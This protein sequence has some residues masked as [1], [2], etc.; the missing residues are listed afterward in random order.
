MKKIFLLTLCLVISQIGNVFASV[1]K[2]T[3]S[4]VNYKISYPIVYTNNKVAQDRINQDIYKYIATFRNYYNEGRFYQGDF[5]Y[6]VKFEDNNYISLTLIVYQYNMGAAHG[7]YIKIGNVYDKN[8]GK[9]LPLSN[10]LR[11]TLNDLSWFPL[12]HFYNE[13]GESIQF[14]NNK[15]DRVSEDYYLLGNGGIALMYQP[16]E[17]APFAY[18]VTTVRFNAEEVEYFNRKNS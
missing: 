11:I 5:S 12:T 7:Q 13:K 4:G 8:S 6:E 1:E 16:Y 2:H 17:L 3:D 10:F 14:N 9:K 15:V 18:G